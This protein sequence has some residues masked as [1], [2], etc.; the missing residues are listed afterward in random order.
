MKT[1]LIHFFN[2]EGALV[3]DGIT[4]VDEEEA[5]QKFL[6]QID[7]TVSIEYIEETSGDLWED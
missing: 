4:G 1:Y 6:A 7:E 3:S 5:K 2:C